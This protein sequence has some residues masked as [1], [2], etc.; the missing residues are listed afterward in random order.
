MGQVNKC[1]DLFKELRWSDLQD[2]A[3][4][5]ATAK[6]I[7][8]Q[9]E[10]RVKELKRTPTGSLVARV[11]GTKEYFTEIFLENG[12]LSS[13]CTCPVGHDCKHG[14]AAVLEYLELAEQGEEAPLASEEDPFVIRA[15]KGYTEAETE[16]EEPSAGALREYLEQLTKRELIEI[17]VAFAEKDALLGRYLRDRQ[18]LA[19]EDVGEIIGEVY[20]ELDELLEETGYSAYENYEI[21]LPDFLN[22]QIG[23]ESLLDSGYSDELLDIGKE[24]MDRYEKIAEYDE[25]G[26]IGTKISFCMDVVFEALFRSSL[27]AHEKML[28]M[29]EIELRDNYNILN[30]HAFWEEDYTSEEWELFAEALKV[31]LQEVEEEKNSLYSPPWQRD[32]AVDRLIDALGKAGLSEEIIPTCEREAE[33]TGNYIRLVELLLD[34]GEKKKAEEWLYRGIKKTREYQPGTA[35]QLFQTLFELKEEEGNWLFATALEAEE[36]F[37]APHTASYPGMQKAARNAGVWKE[38]R[39]AALKYLKTGELPAGQAKA[40]KAESKEEKSKEEISGKEEFSI[41][42]GILPKTGLLEAGSIHKIRTPAL[43]LLI[44]IA[45]QEE[46]PEEVAH[47]YEELKKSGAEAESYWKSISENKIANA[48]KEKYPEIALK[49]WKKLAERLISE[50]KVS[51]YEE[52]SPYLRKIKETLE[53]RGEKEAWEAYLSEIKEVNKRKKRLL[54]ILDRLGADRI[55]G[56]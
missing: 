39:E 34:S 29:L 12:K 24:L 56:E 30:E 23:L 32:Y 49:I 15:R 22:V 1:A 40:G 7:A 8:Y 55:I 53:A 6:G 31:K 50:T 54:E 9:E 45:I 20:S 26:E 47:W 51:S 28:Y 33:K 13:I 16:S 38:V 10:G 19:A 46:D 2:W 41:L 4:G 36:F 35:R 21:D 44:E 37:R 3:G 27:P 18:N 43:D 42:P 14:V 11:E 52:A 5:K 17:L 25:E 48:V